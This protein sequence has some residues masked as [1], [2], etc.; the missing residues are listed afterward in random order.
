YYRTN[1]AKTYC[2][3]AQLIKHSIGLLN[4]K[5]KGKKSAKLIYLYWEPSNA[6]EFYEYL[7]HEKELVD[8]AERM[9][10]ISGLS[11]HYF[12]YLDL[13]ELFSDHSFCNEHLTNFKNR[14]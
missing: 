13:H 5:K 14:Y 12:T 11:F 8:F 6:N 3:T 10:A 9:K 4:Q 2:D 1:N 7:Q